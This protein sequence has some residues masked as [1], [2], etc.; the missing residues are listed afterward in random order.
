M[1]RQL[2]LSLALAGAFAVLVVALL[3]AAALRGG[4]STNGNVTGDG[5]VTSAG[6]SRLVRSES[7]ILGAPAGSTANSAREA[8][9]QVD[10]VEAAGDSVTF[11][12]FLDFECEACR[13]AY[14]FVEELRAEYE[15]RVTFVARFFPLPGHFN[16]ERAARA[17]EAAAQQGAFEAMYQ[18]MYETQEEWGEQQ[19][20]LDDLFRSFAEDLD[21]D[22]AAW[23]KA[24]AAQATTERVAKD[25]EDGIALG[26][27]GTPTF[28][29]DGERLEPR[30]YGDFTDALDAALGD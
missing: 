10:A 9:S 28:F 30:T 19:V 22:M 17:V 25:V 8:A 3:T 14:P 7:H 13:A 6:E 18:R 15:G 5:N 1:T 20:P 2:K 4:D 26:V 12:E 21:L 23:D 11:V 27:Q 24:Y 29:V 16:A